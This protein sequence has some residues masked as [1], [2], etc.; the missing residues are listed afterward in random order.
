[1]PAS[2]KLMLER[3]ALFP[4]AWVPD[5]FVFKDRPAAGS[6]LPAVVRGLQQPAVQVDGTF[7]RSRAAGRQNYA[8]QQIPSPNPP[9]PRAVLPGSGTCFPGV[10]HQEVGDLRLEM[11]QPV[12]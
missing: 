12:R 10:G 7:G 5:A 8:Q 6:S 3:R 4:S 9:A 1:M 2:G 11:K